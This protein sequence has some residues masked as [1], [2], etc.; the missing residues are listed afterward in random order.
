[1]A[2][3]HTPHGTEH[4]GNAVPKVCV[5]LADTAAMHG[6]SQIPEETSGIHAPNTRPLSDRK[7]RPYMPAR[8]Y[9]PEKYSDSA[10]SSNHESIYLQIPNS[11]NYSHD[12]GYRSTGDSQELESSVRFVPVTTLSSSNDG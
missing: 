7:L 9:N 4:L 2:Y 6:A 11:R 5:G 8:H 3:G 10:R 12:S 1:M